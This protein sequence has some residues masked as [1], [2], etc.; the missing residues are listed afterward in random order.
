MPHSRRGC[1]SQRSVV[2][3][4][5]GVL[6]QDHLRVQRRFLP[7]NSDFISLECTKTGEC[8]NQ[9][10]TWIAWLISA[11]T[12]AKRF[13]MSLR[14]SHRRPI[15]ALTTDSSTPRLA[16]PMPAPYNV[17][18]RDRA[19][20]SCDVDAT[21]PSL[22]RIVKRV[23]G[24]GGHAALVWHRRDRA[25]VVNADARFGDPEASR[26]RVIARKL[27]GFFSQRLHVLPSI[28]YLLLHFC[29]GD[30]CIGH[31]IPADKS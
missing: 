21:V 6:L 23:D 14:S 8:Q 3:R 26:L 20:W 22:G 27:D 13:A 5:S 12:R 24:L 31:E 15:V 30:E 29:V 9:P 1:L 10:L 19:S 4:R 11:S 28:K 7:W 25:V 18:A 16:K 17:R 2:Q